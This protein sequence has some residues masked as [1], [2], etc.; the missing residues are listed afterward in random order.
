MTLTVRAS[1]LV[2][3]GSLLTK[4]SQHF[5][6]LATYA[7]STCTAGSGMTN[8]MGLL[9]PKVDQLAGWAKWKLNHCRDMVA[10]TAADLDTARDLFQNTDAQSARRLNQLFDYPIAGRSYYEEFTPWWAAVLPG[11]YE[12][13]WKETPQPSGTPTGTSDLI[14]S[15]KGGL[16]DSCEDYW[17]VFGFDEETLV[18]KLITPITG[19]YDRLYWLY[20]G[21]LNLGNSTYNVAA[22]MRR[23]T[24]EIAPRWNGVA[25]TSF[26]WLMFCWYQGTGGLGDLLEI[27][28]QTVKWIYDEVM[29]LIDKITDMLQELIY[30]HAPD[31][32][33]IFDRNPGSWAE[34][35]CQRLPN[36]VGMVLTDKLSGAE[37]K[38]LSR[39]ARQMCEFVKQVV[40]VIQQV[41]DKY[42]EARDKIHDIWD[43]LDQIRDK[44]LGPWVQDRIA[45]DYQSHLVNLENPTGT[46]DPQHWDPKQGVWRNVLLPT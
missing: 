18:H 24:Y 46:F 39:R 32:K 4:Q 2:D 17:A 37:L 28:S 31:I 6:E 35:S 20:E 13:Q 16:I 15:R 42:H 12:D 10:Q 22:N 38:E 19:D 23:G 1:D 3:M 7:W 8:L 9:A 40:E 25:A 27:C 36:G 33:E 45:K 34:I 21:Y 43:Q 44:G 5:G 26:E 11:S 30:K 14:E 41:E 29:K